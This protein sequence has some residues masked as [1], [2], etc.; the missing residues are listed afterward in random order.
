MNDRKVHARILC[1]QGEMILVE[2]PPAVESR[3]TYGQRV[4]A[5]IHKTEA[6]RLRWEDSLWAD[7]EDDN[8]WHQSQDQRI[9]FRRD[10]WTIYNQEQSA[11]D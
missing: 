3:F 10:P 1:W 2:Y 8:P 5:W 4:T 9:T 6:V 11:G 7:L